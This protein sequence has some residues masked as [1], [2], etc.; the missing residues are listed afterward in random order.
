MSE[1]G[2]AW[3]RSI[4]DLRSLGPGPEMVPV[5]VDKRMPITSSRS[6][7]AAADG[8]AE[9][10]ARQVIA[11]VLRLVN[12]AAPKPAEPAEGGQ[13]GRVACV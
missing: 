3:G 1:G 8:A 12:L 13:P 6:A 4:A 5:C 11:V 2:C 7:V 10:A 9:V